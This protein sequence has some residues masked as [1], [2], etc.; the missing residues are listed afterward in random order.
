MDGINRNRGLSESQL[1]WSLIQMVNGTQQ[2]HFSSMSS[3]PNIEE[4]C[5]YAIVDCKF[6]Q[7]HVCTKICTQ[8]EK[9]YILFQSGEHVK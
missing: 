6:V 3:L 7:M 4:F 1:R 2:V 5:F 9:Y 8:L